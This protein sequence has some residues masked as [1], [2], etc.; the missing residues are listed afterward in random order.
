[1]RL[2]WIAN[3]VHDRGFVSEVAIDV[4]NSPPAG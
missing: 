3:A 4:L 1:M 2:N